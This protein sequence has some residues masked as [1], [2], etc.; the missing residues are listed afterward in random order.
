MKNGLINLFFGLATLGAGV[1]V[2]KQKNVKLL[3]FDSPTPVLVIGGIFTALALYQLIR[4][5]V[6]KPP[7][8]DD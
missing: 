2:L 8:Q 6:R 5:M 3:F 1:Y 4:A 7:P